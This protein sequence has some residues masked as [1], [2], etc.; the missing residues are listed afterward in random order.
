MG[1]RHQ[2]W[3]IAKINGRYHTIAVVHHQWA[4]GH[5]PPRACWRLLQILSHPAN[6]KLV[7][8]ELNYAA[9]FTES[10]WKDL[11]NEINPYEDI[12]K[13]APFPFTATCLA[14]AAAFDPRP[15]T[16]YYH[17]V[18]LLYTGINFVQTDNNDGFTMVDVSNLDDI[19]ICFLFPDFRYVEEDPESGSSQIT[20]PPSYTPLTA[21]EYIAEYADTP[22]EVKVDVDLSCWGLVNADTLRNLWPN[23]YWCNRND[24]G[25][26]GS[27]RIEQEARITSLKELTFIKVIEKHLDNPELGMIE[28]PDFFERLRKWLHAFPEYVK[29][30]HGHRILGLSMKGARC[31]DLSAFHW[32]PEEVIIQ[33][34]KENADVDIVDSIDLS[35][36]TTVTATGIE[37]LLQ[38]CPNITKLFT[39]YTPKL[40][41]DALT[42][43]LA[44]SN[45]DEFLHTELFQSSFDRRGKRHTYATRSEAVTQIVYLS[46]PNSA[47]ADD[48]CCLD[49]KGLR[50]SKLAEDRLGEKRGMSVKCFPV[51]DAFLVLTRATDW[52][53]QLLNFFGSNPVFHTYSWGS[54]IHEACAKAM[55]LELRVRNLNIGCSSY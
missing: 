54:D 53:D 38:V 10:W 41:M 40:S 32:L 22:D 11:E 39:L 12:N 45:V 35:T 28:L 48:S 5:E 27:R 4:Y 16:S 14:L 13:L 50:W 24:D 23:G 49:Q 37:K 1:Q 8:H 36:N 25:P 19:H 9:T 55:A 26:G 20:R 29:A 46:V 33:L 52:L 44:G 6:K 15:E 17:S 21:E 30:P 2:Y 18:S 43:A 34:V 51:R 47:K 7:A 42:G 31:L 3:I